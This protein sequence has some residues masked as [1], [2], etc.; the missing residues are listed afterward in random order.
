MKYIGLACIGVL[1]AVILILYLKIRGGIRKLSQAMFQ[2][3]SFIKGYQSNGERLASTPKSVSG[4]TNIYAPLIAKDFPE[5]NLQEY[6][7]KA[8]VMLRS[9][10]AAV[11]AEDIT[12]L[13]YASPTLRRFVEGKIAS[14]KSSGEREKFEDV[15]IY[16]TE[17]AGYEKKNGTCFITFQSAV[18]YFHTTVKDGKVIEGSSELRQQVKYDTQLIYIQDET[19]L[20]GRQGDKALGLTCPNCGA[21]IKTLGK[22]YCAYCG[23]AIQA[24]DIYAWHFHAYE[25]V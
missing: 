25:L 12:L 4:M 20:E 14:S 6:A 11:S 19:L 3:D 5:L 7:T 18:G 17:I 13:E 21:P 1:I 23:C 15:T 22:K 16:Q 24:L 8:E 10:L 2:S 9:A